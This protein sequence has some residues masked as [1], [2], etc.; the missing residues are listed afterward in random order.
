MNIVIRGYLCLFFWVAVGFPLTVNAFTEKDFENLVRADN[1]EI[2][3]LYDRFEAL[4]SNQE[5]AELI[6]GWQAVGGL[7]SRMDK[8]PSDDPNFTYDSIKTTGVQFGLQKAFSFGLESKLSLNSTQTEITNGNAGSGNFD[9][10]IWETQ[11]TLDLKLPLLSGGFGRKI[12]AEYQSEVFRK[13]LAALEAESLYDSKMN[14]AKIL[15]WS[16][17][18]QKE[19]LASQTE[20]LNRIQKIYQIVSRKAA[21]NLEASS[22]FLQ[23]RSAL[24]SAELDLKNAQLKYS[25][26]ER[27]L[28]L[29]LKKINGIQVP[30]YDFNK[31][32]KVDLKNY[33][34]KV[35][36]EQ[37]MMSI[38]E[39]LQNQTAIAVQEMNRSRLDLVASLAVSGQDRDWNESY[40][41]S[42]NG[43]YPTQ[44]FGIQW[45]IP[46]D[47][48]ITSRAIHRQEIISKAALAKQQ[49]L[50]TEQKQALLNDLVD[51]VNQMVDMLSLN[52]RLEKTQGEK[53]KNERQL[54]NQGRS[55]IYQVLQFELDLARAQAGK[56]LLALELEK[57]YQ[58]L[59]QYRYESY[60]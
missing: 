8:R 40:N 45:V 31:F 1:V 11:P 4:K 56:F 42:R 58:Q 47:Q 24:E 46:F 19:Q 50:Q 53:L 33:A 18:L 16:T 27:L 13:R 22:N 2:K 28:N 60:E 41:Q 59:A 37:K 43:R 23:T 55:S 30:K 57:A 35:T 38:S 54:L 15:L 3:A 12:R 32:R 21:L 14:E 51:Q 9:S 34:H 39:D 44:F 49:Y 20:T 7:N 5:E 17:I 6:Y 10:K 26:L 52:L 48:G 25:Q 36:P 29:V